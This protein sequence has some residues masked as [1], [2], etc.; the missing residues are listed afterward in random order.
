MNKFEQVS[1]DDYQM[2]LVGVGM[3]RGREYVQGFACQER[4]CPGVG[5]FG[6]R[7][8][9][10]GRGRVALPCDL[11]HDACDVTYPPHPHRQ[12][13]ACENITFPQLLLRVV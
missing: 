5:V 13:D 9:C 1:S 7:W 3:S 2:L 4:V 6:S 12:T 11:S 8:V 10:W